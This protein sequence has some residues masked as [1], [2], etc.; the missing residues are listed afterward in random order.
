MRSRIYYPTYPMGR[1]LH[2]NNAQIHW[3]WHNGNIVKAVD[4]E[5]VD[6]MNNAELRLPDGDGSRNQIFLGLLVLIVIA[7]FLPMLKRSK[8]KKSRRANERY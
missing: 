6:A 8:K 1:V 3:E 5:I 2:A 4:H 7:S